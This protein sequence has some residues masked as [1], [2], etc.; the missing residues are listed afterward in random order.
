MKAAVDHRPLTRPVTDALGERFARDGY[1][2]VD[3]LRRPD[4]IVWYGRAY[5]RLLSGDIDAGARRGDLGSSAP[6]QKARV[7]NITQVMWPSRS[8]EPQ[9]VDA[10]SCSALSHRTGGLAKPHSPRS[11]SPRRSRPGAGQAGMPSARSV[12]AY[13]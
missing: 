7:E 6:R 5:D 4:E 13:S 11:R 12:G 3:G 10:L 2:Q 1:V 9:P 8:G